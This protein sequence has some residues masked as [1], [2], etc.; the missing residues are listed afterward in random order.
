VRDGAYLALTRYRPRFYPGKIKFVRAETSSA[1]PDDAAAVWAPLA[2]KFEVETVPGD[3]LGI[4]A[5]HYET[6]ATVL[7][8]YLVEAFAENLQRDKPDQINQAR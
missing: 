3:H 4:I 2:E 7:S 6:L 1:F 5:T 8:Q